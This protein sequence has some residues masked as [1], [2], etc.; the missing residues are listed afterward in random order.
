[1]AN[2]IYISD[3]YVNVSTEVDPGGDNPTGTVEWLQ[4]LFFDMPYGV[5]SPYRDDGATEFVM[6]RQSEQLVWPRGTQYNSSSGMVLYS[7][8]DLNSS[9]LATNFAGN[10]LGGFSLSVRLQGSDLNPQNRLWRHGT[11]KRLLLPSWDRWRGSNPLAVASVDLDTGQLHSGLTDMQ[12]INGLNI[13]GGNGNFTRP[14]LHP[15]QDG[16]KMIMA[17]N[18]TGSFPYSYR[19]LAKVELDGADQFVGLSWLNEPADPITNFVV[20]GASNNAIYTAVPQSFNNF[21]TVIEK[22]DINTGEPLATIDPPTGQAWTQFY[23]YS[24]TL[25]TANSMYVFFATGPASTSN[26][27]GRTGLAVHKISLTTNQVVKSW[28]LTGRPSTPGFTS[29]TTDFSALAGTG[30]DKDGRLYLMYN[31]DYKDPYT[32]LPGTDGVQFK[33]RVYRVTLS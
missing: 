5:S 22:R 12:I 13:T 26:P 23:N 31:N 30:F 8:T 21:A 6:D 32:A 28:D 19:R 33:F 20:L 18:P 7:V 10:A 3:T 24:R 1:M 11:A 16:S 25:F 14:T 4:P 2:I 27:N 15:S 9:V 29:S 17:L